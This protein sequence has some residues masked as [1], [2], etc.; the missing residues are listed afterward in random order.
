MQKRHVQTFMSVSLLGLAGNAAAHPGYHGDL[1][2][3]DK[4]LHF[5]SQPDH[6]NMIVTGAF[7]LIGAVIWSVVRKG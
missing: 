3:W 5:I 6:V 4:L 1:Q 2:S 7:M